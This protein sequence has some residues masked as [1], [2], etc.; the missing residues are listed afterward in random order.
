MIFRFSSM[1]DVAM[2][3]PVLRCLYAQNQ[4]IQVTLVTRKQF[5]PIFKEFIELQIIS[6]DF[7]GKHKGLKGLYRLYRELK[8]IKPHRIA[9]IHQNL[10]SRILGLFFRLSFTRIKV[11]DKGYTE[12]KRLTR[13]TK[14][15]MKPL[16]P[17]HFRYVEVFSRLGFA[18]DVDKH[19]FPI[20]PGLPKSSL[21]I[22]L[23]SDRKWIGIAPFAEHPGK[24][25]PLDL[26]QKVVGYL[27]K[28]YTVFLLGH[29]PKEAAQIHVWAKAYPHVIP[30]ALEMSFSDQLNLIA[31]LDVMISMDSANGHLAAN[32]GVPVITLWGMTHP[33]LGFSAFGQNNHLLVDRD[34]FPKVPTS[35]CGKLVPKGYNDAM[36]TITPEDVIEM[37]LEKI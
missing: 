14:K 13:P 20:K 31:N 9:D 26:M 2:L 12:R 29:G 8:Q 25:Y 19:E 22:D 37:V 10:R 30:N 15:T 16:T 21:E 32:F 3:V 24:I 1:G 23:P 4:K 7:I 5:S 35:P 17:Q 27:Q 36:R 34:K 33:F 6:P 11:I 28:Q 18:L